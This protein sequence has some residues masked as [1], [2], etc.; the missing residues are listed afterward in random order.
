MGRLPQRSEIQPEHTW[1][2][3]SVFPDDAA[4]ETELATLADSFPGLEA[5]QGHLGD[6]PA[7]LADWFARLRFLHRPRP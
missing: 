2:A 3:Q 5:F 7:M 6:G 4:W 1:D